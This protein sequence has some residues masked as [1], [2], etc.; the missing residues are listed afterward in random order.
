MGLTSMKLLG[1]LSRSLRASR[2][3]LGLERLKPEQHQKFDG[4]KFTVSRPSKFSDDVKSCCSLASLVVGNTSVLDMV[5]AGCMVFWKPDSGECTSKS[6]KKR[7]I[8]SLSQITFL[9]AFT[10]K[11][12][13]L[14]CVVLGR[15]YY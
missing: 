13:F 14:F 8:S 4:S 7:K 15:A 5:G 3:S 12:L 11:I 6:S 2:A 9:F 1:R 10:S